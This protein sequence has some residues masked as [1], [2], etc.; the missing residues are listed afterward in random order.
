MRRDALFVADQI[1][2]IG[3]TCE[4]LAAGTLAGT[5]SLDSSQPAFRYPAGIR[6]LL[7]R[8]TSSQL[9]CL[10]TCHR[11]SGGSYGGRAAHGPL[12]SAALAHRTDSR[13]L[14]RTR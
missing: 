2:A 9:L 14:A 11:Y 5:T 13:H 7:L 4:D 3:P 12:S 8:E 10:A 1:R 6:I